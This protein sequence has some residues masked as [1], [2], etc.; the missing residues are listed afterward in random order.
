MLFHGKGRLRGERVVQGALALSSHASQ[1]YH[2]VMPLYL[3]FL[4]SQLLAL[5]F[6]TE[7]E[8]NDTESVLI[9]KANTIWGTCLH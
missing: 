2:H 1:T 3:D 8:Q 6:Q 9:I 5:Q 4:T 7:I